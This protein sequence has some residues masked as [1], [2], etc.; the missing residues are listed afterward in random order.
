MAE[1][2]SV[3]AKRAAFRELHQAGCFAIRRVRVPAFE[4]RIDRAIDAG[5]A[6]VSIEDAGEDPDGDCAAR[7]GFMQ[8][9][10]GLAEQGRF[11]GFA[12]ALPGADP[13]AFFGA[14]P[15]AGFPPVRS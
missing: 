13:N 2:K 11:D 1:S 9:A 14:G 8:A 5:V 12:G 6:G 4:I 10:R 3:S 7:G 15:G